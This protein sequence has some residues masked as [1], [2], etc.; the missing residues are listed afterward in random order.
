MLIK[1]NRK[2]L[3]E[4]DDMSASTGGS[5]VSA[6]DE[7]ADLL[8]GGDETDTGDEAD[9]ETDEA[10]ESTEVE[11]S[12]EETEESDEDEESS[13]EE[14]GEDDTWATALGVDDSNI[15]INED[16]DLSGINVKI[17]G[18]SSTVQIKDLIMGYQTNKHNTNTSQSLA[19]EKQEFEV[20]REKAVT[21]YNTK[22][23]DLNKLTEYMQNTLM[24]EF[25]GVDW[26]TL[27]TSDPAEYAAAQQDFSK[28]QEDIQS[29]FAAISDERTTESDKASQLNQQRTNDF[30]KLEM[31]KVIDSNPEWKEPAKLQQAFAD[32]GTFVN[33]SYGISPDEFNRINDARHIELVKDAMA[34]RNGKKILAKG[35]KAKLPKY[36]KSRKSTTSKKV[37]KLDRLTKAASHS[38]G[39]AKK[40][41]QTDAI[42]ALLME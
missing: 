6:T 41:A 18:K 38:T 10:D 17:D 20:H 23:E 36:Q 8:V 13:D 27:R 34:Y 16:G 40:G 25:N 42:A 5:D 4:Q 19:S 33:E 35:P 32:M 21:R 22:L 1:T 14:S 39:S 37:S 2:Y 29:I 7:I 28:R 30:L 26:Q 24:G 31:V 11:E 3:A 9:I 12:N 15:S